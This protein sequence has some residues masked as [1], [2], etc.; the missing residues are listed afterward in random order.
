MTSLTT[1][2]KQPQGNVVEDTRDTVEY[3]DAQS[4]LTVPTPPENDQ[5]DA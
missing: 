4:D 2:V 3:L 5:K 1:P